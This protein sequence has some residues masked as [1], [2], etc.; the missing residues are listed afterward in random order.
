MTSSTCE[1]YKMESK[2]GRGNDNYGHSNGFTQ[3]L[4]IA[5]CTHEKCTVQAVGCNG[6]V[7]FCQIDDPPA[8]PS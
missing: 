8:P 5:K 6:V 7:E 3:F 4:I 2:K 1:H